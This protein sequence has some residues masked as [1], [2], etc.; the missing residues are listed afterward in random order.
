MT[1]LQASAIFATGFCLG[2][3]AFDKIFSKR[4]PEDN[5]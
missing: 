3:L 4:D 5:E 1:L 2:A